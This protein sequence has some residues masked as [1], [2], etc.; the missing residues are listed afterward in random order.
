MKT[1]PY[2]IRLPQLVKDLPDLTE[3]ARHSTPSDPTCL[4]Q[5]VR[6]PLAREII[7]AIGDPRLTPDSL[8]DLTMGPA[9]T[10]KGLQDIINQGYRTVFSAEALA[11]HA[12]DVQVQQGRINEDDAPKYANGELDP[13]GHIEGV[14]ANHNFVR[15]PVSESNPYFISPDF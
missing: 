13:S 12:L 10:Q 14:I 11:V 15:I 3:E 2:I 4:P 8:D 1:Y 9:T 6:I 5:K 7:Y